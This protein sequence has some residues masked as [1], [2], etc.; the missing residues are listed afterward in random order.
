MAVYSITY[1]L[2]NETTRRD[3][4]GIRKAIQA[5]PAWTKLCDSSYLV[6][7]PLSAGQVYDVLSPH[8]DSDDHVMVLPVVRPY[9]G[10][11]R[12][13]VLAWLRERV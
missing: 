6:D 8:V 13:E 9:A 4:N 7:T 12:V 11:N 2:N 5:F 10:R 1:D 3:H